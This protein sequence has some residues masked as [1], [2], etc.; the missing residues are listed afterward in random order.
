MKIEIR[1]LDDLRNDKGRLLEIVEIVGDNYSRTQEVAVGA[2]IRHAREE[3]GHDN[4]EA[5]TDA[6]IFGG[7]YVNP[8]TGDCIIAR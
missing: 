3:F 1:I 4:Y 6:S 8:S 5:R 7:Y 2:M